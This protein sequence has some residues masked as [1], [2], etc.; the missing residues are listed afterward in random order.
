M[1]V[2]QNGGSLLRAPRS[3]AS[4]MAARKAS[5]LPF[6]R[7]PAPEL[8]QDRELCE[9]ALAGES[10]AS[11]LLYRRHVHAVTERVTRLLARSSEAEDVVQDTFVEALAGLAKLDDRARFGPWLMRIAVHQVHRRFRRRRLLAR[12][13][14]DRGSDDAGLENVADP[15]LD[16]ERRLQLRR[17]DSE[18]GRLPVALRLAWMLRY[19][20]GCELSDAAAQCGCSLA[21]FKRRLQRADARLRARLGEAPRVVEGRHV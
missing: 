12:L 18:L 16:P 19:V 2:A 15:G 4:D 9:R 3:A 13:G 1:F 10:L 6:L 17:L 7:Q 5:V 20:E 8:P 21:T 11:Q 14:L